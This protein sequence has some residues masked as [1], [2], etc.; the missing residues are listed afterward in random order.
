MTQ[1]RLYQIINGSKRINGVVRTEKI[2]VQAIEILKTLT[3]HKVNYEQIG[4]KEAEEYRKNI[5]E[6]IRIQ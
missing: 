4:D 1:Y 3:N 2:A 5:R 6:K